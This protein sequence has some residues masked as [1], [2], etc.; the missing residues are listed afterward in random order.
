VACNLD[1]LSV[2]L[3]VLRENPCISSIFLWKSAI[4]FF[5]NFGLKNQEYVP[6]NVAVLYLIGKIIS[7]IF[8]YSWKLRLTRER[9]EVLKS[10]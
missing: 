3:A 9:S 7:F 4:Y 2:N 6:K 8:C 5:A 1:A 10:F